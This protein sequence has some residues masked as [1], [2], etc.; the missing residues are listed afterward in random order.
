MKQLIFI[1]LLLLSSISLASEIDS[2]KVFKNTMTITG[3]G[4]NSITQVKLRNKHLNLLPISKTQMIVSCKTFNKFPCKNDHW[5]SG[6]YMLKLFG[7]NV[8]RAKVKFP[9][10]ITGNEIDEVIE[11]PIDV[12][13][14]PAQLEN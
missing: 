3:D 8:N 13:P 1:S 10:Y 7:Q 5:V 12:K 11:R 4:F 6:N 14:N 2:V 9:I